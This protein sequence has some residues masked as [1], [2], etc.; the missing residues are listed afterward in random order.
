MLKESDIRPDKLIAEQKRLYQLD[1]QDLL[2]RKNEFVSVGCP[3]CGQA[4]FHKEW[5]KYGLNFVRCENCRTVFTNPRPTPEILDFYYSHSR[6][7]NYWNEFI[8]PASENI[9][10]ERIFKPRAQLINNLC[11]EFGINK[12]T[13]IDVGAGFGTFAEEI[14]LSGTFERVVAVEPNPNLAKTCRLKGIETIEENVEEVKFN[15][16]VEVVTSFEVIEHL[17]Y[18]KIFIEN[19]YRILSK[20]G[21]LV[22]TCPNVDGFDI[23]I[24]N[25]ISDSVDTEHLNYFNLDSLA[26]LLKEIGF[27]ILQKSTPGQLDAELV[28]KKVFNG[29]FD[30]INQNFLKSILFNKWEEVGENFQ[31][32]LTINSLSSNMLIVARK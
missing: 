32:F 20:G 25:E 27:N 10:R 24:L 19:C 3:A 5:K 7:Y 4:R 15:E 13:I 8:F 11:E 9:R 31:K 18:P 17:F 30:L 1:I 26:Y 6:N 16:K 28:R 23:S 21:I 12:G 22:L 14:K 2:K 29:E